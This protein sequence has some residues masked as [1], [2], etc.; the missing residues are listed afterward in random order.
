MWIKNFCL[1]FIVDNNT[2]IHYF[3]FFFYT[4]MIVL[5][6][7]NRSYLNSYIKQDNRKVWCL[8]MGGP[9]KYYDYSTKNMKKAVTPSTSEK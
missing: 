5:Y 3:K 2:Y 7:K 8:I 4:N 6:I 1:F 9:T